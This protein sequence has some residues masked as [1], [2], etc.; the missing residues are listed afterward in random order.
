MVFD[1]DWMKKLRVQVFERDKVCKS[2]K[3]TEDLGMA[4]VR[5]YDRNSPDAWI[6]LC[7]KCRKDRN[8]K[9]RKT[10]VRG[11]DSCKRIM[12]R[13]IEEQRLEIIELRNKILRMK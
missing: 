1:K 7:G 5:K 10:I 12:L 11:K 6:C 2:C 13:K 9:N 3:T 4:C 8:E